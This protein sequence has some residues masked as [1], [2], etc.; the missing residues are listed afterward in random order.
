MLQLMCSFNEPSE[1]EN[2]FVNGS[3]NAKCTRCGKLEGPATQTITRS[4]LQ[5][6]ASNT[7]QEASFSN[8]QLANILK[9]NL[10]LY[11]FSYHASILSMHSGH[12]S[13]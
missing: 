6:N 13:F 2:R 11:H 9:R 1:M 4:R 5:E 10:Y 12:L 8:H 7:L 3:W